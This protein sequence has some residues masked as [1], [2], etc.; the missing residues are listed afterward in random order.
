MKILMCDLTHDTIA[1]A[2]EVFPLNIGL[3]ASHLINQCGAKTDVELSKFIEEAE[4]LIKSNDYDL[5]AFSNYPWNIEAGLQLSRIAVKKNANTVIIFG[6]PNFP[7][8][9]N[10]QLR[11][12]K[13]NSEIDAYVFQGGEIPFTELV[14][15]L[16][17]EPVEI[18]K[19]LLKEVSLKGVVSVDKNGNRLYGGL[20]PEPKDL[21]FIPSPYLEGLL[22][23]FFLDRRLSP[24]IQTNRGCPFKCTFCADGHSS[25]NKVKSFSVERVKSELLYIAERID[26][27]LQK[28]L[29]ISDLNFGMFKRDIEIADLIADISAKMNYPK[30]IDA[31]TGK[32][33]KDRIIKAV[34]K[35]SGS[36]QMSMAM[37]STDPEVLTNIKRDN[38][39]LEDYTAI[40]PSLK[41]VNLNTY[42][43]IILGLPGETL[44]SHL[45][46]I[47]ELLL[48]KVDNVVPHS[49]M[50]LNGA[51]LN[52][53][54]SRELYK[55]QSRY[56]VLTRDFSVIGG[57]Y[58]V[59]TEE[60]A[61]SSKD[62]SFDEYVYARKVAFILSLINNPGLSIVV[63]V[64]IEAN[65]KPIEL[66]QFILDNNFNEI[67]YKSCK[68]R[69]K[70][71]A[72]DTVDELW[73]SE[74]DMR[75]YYKVA[76]NFDKLVE[77]VDG[78]NLIQSHVTEWISSGLDDLIEVVKGWFDSKG[79]SND[80][81][82]KD[83]LNYAKARTSHVFS[84]DRVSKVIKIEL[85]YDLASWSLNPQK[86]LSDFKL[87][88]PTKASFIISDDQYEMLERQLQI[89]GKT[90]Q[91][92]SKAYI[93][94]GSHNLWRKCTF[95]SKEP[96]SIDQKI[97]RPSSKTS[98]S[99][100]L[101]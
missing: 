93:R 56:R 96:V 54:D 3:V 72:S 48:F 78:K 98:S 4:D 86:K 35:L 42:G 70:K 33:S 77:G 16:M 25:Q 12:L 57:E 76:E 92:L 30:Y 20:I 90:P 60:V 46:T 47:N 45:N 8:S 65:L 23:K 74:D 11:F 24:M 26:P 73:E 1:L 36:L 40:M 84:D 44:K 2:N 10:E 27:K 75:A 68:A 82:V 29:F 81:R 7:Y 71:F 79:L 39:R 59:E 62:L 18:R 22:D 43:E 87:S 5:I 49:L 21:D 58:V 19:R 52:T 66:I 55:Y 89:F 67:E 14:E 101:Y 64:A 94:T 53:D 17:D 80:Q 63:N 34:E 69:V 38:I 88:S 95:P 9:E 91:G 97:M 13:R 50:M 99:S 83:A 51:E 85:N 41:A 31:T 61:V 37:Q 32:N 100:A 15:F 6:G 28:T